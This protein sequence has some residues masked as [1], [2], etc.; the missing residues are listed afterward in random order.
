MPSV[1]PGYEYD[2]FISYRHNDNKSG[3]VT[4]FVKNLQEELAAT[5]KEPLSVYFDSNPH[6]GLLETHDVEDSLENKL[7][8][9]IFIPVV[10]QTYCDPKSF[11]WNNEF[12][13]FKNIASVDKFGLKIKLTN[14]NVARRILPVRIHDLD[15]QDKLFLE[16]QIGPLRSVDFVFTSSGVN[17][18]LTSH[19]IHPNDN[20]NRIFYS[21]QINRLANAIKEIMTCLKVSSQVMPTQQLKKWDPSCSSTTEV[22]E[23]RFQAHSADQHKSLAVLPFVNISNDPG[24][25]YFSDGLTEEIIADLS[26][27]NNVLV[28]SRSSMMTFKGSGKKIREIAE[29][30][31]V[32]YVLEGSV[33]KAGNSLRITAQLIDSFNDCHLWAGKYDGKIDDVFDIQEKVSRAIVD[34]LK[35]KLTEEQESS[36]TRHPIQNI[37]AYECYIRARHEMLK[38]TESGLQNSVAL[39]NRGLKM[40]G[41]NATLYAAL[42]TAY[43][44]FHHFGL[45]LDSRI[46]TEASSFASK[47]LALDKHCMQAHVVNGIVQFKNGNLQ[48][49][50]GTF[51][52][53][54]STDPV[55]V[56]A[57]FWLIVC[58]FIS[59]KADAGTPLSKQ[60][61]KID[62]L[63]PISEAV[64]AW[65]EY[66]AGRIEN[67]I[68]LYRKWLQLDPATPFTRWCC[69]MVFGYAKKLDECFAVLDSIIRD[70][71]GIVFARHALFYKCALMG[72]REGALQCVH[73]ELNEEAATNDYL[74]LHMAAGFALIDEKE[75]AVL[76]L[77]RASQLGFINYPLMQ[78]DP[79]FKRMEG[80]EDFSRWK[81]EIKLRWEA[82]V[83]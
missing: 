37:Q 25:E 39:L 64:P 2:I 63:S 44:Y 59:G 11:A 28:I 14:G 41:D 69:A 66:Y 18:P 71:P 62:P 34:A 70:M 82:F 22:G 32:R 33:R 17:R 40:V 74:P 9:A 10:S 79:I 3:W 47:S 1:I 75:K 23:M 13:V 72:D 6:D 50:A 48:N 43:L 42:G 35:L 57:L 24:Q 78:K 53:V 45:N 29:E 61:L 68:P 81:E 51:K 16:D 77:R 7:K 4:E 76:W 38:F 46:L 20:L 52:K 31:K 80:Y 5:I 56:D 55:N 36:L 67:A 26:V 8:S 54:L 73:H 30:V 83:L 65:I 19:E 15:P 58:Y 49:A 27:L 60:L 12:I 21:D